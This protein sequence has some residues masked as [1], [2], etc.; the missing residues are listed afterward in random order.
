ML[1]YTQAVVCLLPAVRGQ[2]NTSQD[3]TMELAYKWITLANRHYYLYLNRSLAQY[4]LNSSQYL[5]IIYLCREPGITQDKLPERI[6]INKSNVTRTLAQL[7][8]KGLIHRQVNPVDKRT[9]A[10]FPTPHAYEL[11]PKIM[12]VIQAWDDAVTGVLS[13]QQ[14]QSLLALMQRV[15]DRAGELHGATAAALKK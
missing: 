14:K 11:Y 7:E 6:C 8:K 12:A 4:G 9:A 2:A 1:R 3:G 5:F 15:A 10:V 13:P